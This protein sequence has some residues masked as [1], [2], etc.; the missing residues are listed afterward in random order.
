M[1]RLRDILGAVKVSHMEYF[2]PK[3][4]NVSNVGEFLKVAKDLA[5][6]HWGRRAA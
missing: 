4:T 1:S 6:P 3:E 2:C 5:D